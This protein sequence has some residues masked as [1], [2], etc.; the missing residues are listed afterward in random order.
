MRKL[1][2]AHRV[3]LY[4]IILGISTGILGSVIAQ[5]P[6]GSNLFPLKCVADIELA[7]GTARFDY[8][9]I[10][11]K[12]RRLYIAHLGADMV[13]VFDLSKNAVVTN[14]TGI[15]RPHGIRAV[16]GNNRV[17]VSATGTDQIVVLDPQTF[18]II[19]RIDAGHFP[20]GIAYDPADNKLFV[21]DE[22]GKTVT[23]IDTST[24]RVITRIK[25]G[26]EPGNTHYDPILKLIYTAV[27]TSNELVVID[28]RTNNIIT[29]YKLRWCRG[30][31]GFYIDPETNYA[32]V[33]C[34][35]N[36]GY[37]VFDLHSAR[38]IDHGTVGNG[39]DVLAFDKIYHLLYVASESGVISVYTIGKNDIKKIYQGFFARNAHTVAVD[40][41]THRVFFPLQDID[42]KPVLRIMEPRERVI[43]SIIG[44]GR[45]RK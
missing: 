37:V 15:S 23:V 38:T 13:T 36:A 43:G 31:H 20:D 40:Q 3:V 1:K 4:L 39:P 44:K 12:D 29:R 30:A 18:R 11:E 7:G 2:K 22:F 25:M 21:S 28:P 42:G 27:Q 5:S 9:S 41:V 26:G 17:Y 19:H 24:N 14:I 33:T 45:N 6:F 8:Q 34:Q 16:S 32:F 10:D 35:D